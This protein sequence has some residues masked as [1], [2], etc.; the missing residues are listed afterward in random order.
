MIILYVPRN[1]QTGRGLVAVLCF[2][3]DIILGIARGEMR[4]SLAIKGCPG[5]AAQTALNAALRQEIARLRAEV[6]Q[7][8]AQVKTLQAQLRLTSANSHQPPSSDPPTPA[9]TREARSPAS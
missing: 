4:I 7:L 2:L 5:C 6:T 3:F 9:R 8:Q 1:C